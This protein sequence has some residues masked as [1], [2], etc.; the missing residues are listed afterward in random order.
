MRPPRLKISEAQ[1]LRAVLDYAELHGWRSAHFRPAMNRRGRWETPMTGRDAKGFP[2]L[3]LVRDRIVIAELKS[4][5]GRPSIEQVEWIAVLK[6]AGVETY[7]WRP[8]SWPEIEA[9]LAMR[10]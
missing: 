9:T 5:T 10:R 6:R 7:I 1:F 4:A 3:V 2:D 8:G